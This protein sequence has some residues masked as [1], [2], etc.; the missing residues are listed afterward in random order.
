MTNYFLLAIPLFLMALI[1]GLL[2]KNWKKW[3]PIFKKTVEII[4]LVFNIIII[5]VICYFI[6]KASWEPVTNFFIINY[7]CILNIIIYPLNLVFLIGNF[8]G[9]YFL[10]DEFAQPSNNPED[11]KIRSFAVGWATCIGGV[12]NFLLV[13]LLLE[14][15]P[16]ASTFT[17][18]EHY[19]RASGFENLIPAFVTLAL[20][21]WSMIPLIFNRIRHSSADT[22]TAEPE[23]Y[24]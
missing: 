2:L 15:G 20:S 11:D 4:G 16:F 19:S 10:F 7:I 18:L 14:F 8:L 21:C 1:T 5:L 22:S 23:G 24:D 13:S 6:I 17:A 9:L 12:L 3:I